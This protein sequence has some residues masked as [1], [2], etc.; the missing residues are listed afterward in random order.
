MAKNYYA[1]LGV[2]PN[3][4]AKQLKQRFRELARQRHPDRFQGALKVQAEAEFQDITEAFN[5]LSDPVRRRQHDSELQRPRQTAAANDPKQL[6]RVFLNRGIRAYKAQSYLEAA[7]NFNRVTEI[8]PQDPQGWHHLAL[9]CLEEERWLPKAREAIERACELAPEKVSYLKL[10]GRIFARSG[11][12]SRAKAY[13]NEA[14][15][16][17]G[18]DAALRQALEELAG[19]AEK[20]APKNSK[21]RLF[22]KSW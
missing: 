4:T 6:A 14:L 17:G 18:P 19:P 16:V 8:D 9:T 12:A 11:M 21:S 10:A 7:S 13:Y 22:G 5:V 1:I 20:A 15:R 2:S 3:V